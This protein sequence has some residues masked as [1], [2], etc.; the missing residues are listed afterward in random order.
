MAMTKTV[1]RSSCGGIRDCLVAV[2]Q[3]WSKPEEALKNAIIGR[4]YKESKPETMR[5]NA[6]GGAPNVPG[7]SHRQSRVRAVGHVQGRGP[8]V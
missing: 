7:H 3:E 2:A 1:L 8:N 6:R 5:T 4:T